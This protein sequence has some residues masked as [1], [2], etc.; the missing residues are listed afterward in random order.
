MVGTVLSGMDS[1]NRK[2]LE[3]IQ[4]DFPVD[5]RP[6][7]VLAN[8]LETTEEEILRR[9]RGLKEQGIIRRLGGVFDSRK[10]GYKSTLCAMEVPKEK[11]PE[12]AKVI[13]SYVGVTHNYIRKHEYNLWFTLITPSENKMNLILQEIKDKTG[14]SAMSLPA[15]RLFKIK[16]SFQVP[17][18]K[19]DGLKCSAK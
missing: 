6:Y 2:L 19:E 12:V 9:L 5:P 13:N 3:L 11:I 17:G 18:L 10:L 16:V 1:L 8:K 15:K 4:N 14:Y 7:Q